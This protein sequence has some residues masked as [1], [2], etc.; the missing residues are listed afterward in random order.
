[1]V[2]L[3]LLAGKRAG[4]CHSGRPGVGVGRP[5][6]SDRASR[7]APGY[8]QRHRCRLVRLGCTAAAARIMVRGWGSLW[9]PP[10]PV[11]CMVFRP[12]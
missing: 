6:G 2:M 11:A 8:G 5:A 7:V 1:L 9:W 3:V 4:V 10:R 12:C